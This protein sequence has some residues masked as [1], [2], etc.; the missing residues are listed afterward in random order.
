MVGKVHGDFPA[1][2]SGE[3]PAKSFEEIFYTNIVED[4]EGYATMR[5]S[6]GGGGGNIFRRAFR[7]LSG[8]TEKWVTS[9]FYYSVHR[10][11]RL[12]TIVHHLCHLES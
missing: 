8:D 9:K 2:F 1:N 11:A 3:I 7:R 6:C 12:N 10:N 5:L 4:E